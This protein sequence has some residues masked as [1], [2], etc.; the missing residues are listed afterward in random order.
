M[1][2]RANIII[3]YS[4]GAEVCF[5]THWQ[6]STIGQTL[7]RALARGERWDDEGGGM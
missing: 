2:D 1:G 6:G 4:T 3:K 5:Y 7:Q